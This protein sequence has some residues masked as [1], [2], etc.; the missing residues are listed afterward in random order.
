M[1]TASVS[2][3]EPNS[4]EAELRKKE[5]KEHW[6]A[7]QQSGPLVST[8]SLR[9]GYHAAALKRGGLFG[10][11]GYENEKEAQ[12]ASGVKSSTW[13][14]VQR[15]AEAF[16]N[17]EE[18]LFCAMRLSNAETLMDLP[19]SKRLTEYWM[20]RAATDSIDTFKAVI[21]EE[22]NG[23]SKPSD[24][25]EKIVPFSVKMTKSQ[26]KAVDAGL[27][28]YAKA[29]G[30]EGNEARAIELLVAE[31]KEGVSLV[32]AISHAI[33][34]IAA[35]KEL[36]HG[37]LSAAEVLEKAYAELDGIVSE[38]RAALENLQNGN[39]EEQ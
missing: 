20:R 6:K 19:E 27:Q 33:E 23:K 16:P 8:N 22:M 21:D 32:G 17:V 38:F 4:E 9:I 5:A 10:I 35:I 11:L 24:G 12:E 25:R 18:K 37:N 1:A 13:F 7:I 29:A 36:G 15:I 34:R 3:L 28:E 14:N 39:S 31:H 2:I 26:K 30:C